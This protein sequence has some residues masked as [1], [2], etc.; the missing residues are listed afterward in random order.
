MP[1]ARDARARRQLADST[2]DGT[3]QAPSN[4][5]IAKEQAERQAEQAAAQL[6]QEEQ[7]AAESAQHARGRSAS[8]KARQKQRKQ[9]GPPMHCMAFA[10]DLA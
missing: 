3:Q 1:Q 7:T 8:K 5:A 2:D 6:L 4:E 9:V 10:C